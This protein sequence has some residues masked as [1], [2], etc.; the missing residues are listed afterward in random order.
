[1]HRSSFLENPSRYW[2]HSMFGFL[3][4]GAC[5]VTS[6]GTRCIYATHHL[7]H[8]RLRR[9][10]TRRIVQLFCVFGIVCQG[11]YASKHQMLLLW[12]VKEY[13][14]ITDDAKFGN[15]SRTTS[16]S[17]TMSA[18]ILFRYARDTRLGSLGG[19]RTGLSILTTTFAFVTSFAPI[20]IRE[21]KS[22]K[23][24]RVSK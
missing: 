7:S 15:L 24:S 17:K 13:K 8:F 16:V 5:A 10:Q 4:E 2:L 1:M 20:W 3:L 22:D 9:N 12:N 6:I 19:R 11:L 14:E 18:L 21:K 23:G